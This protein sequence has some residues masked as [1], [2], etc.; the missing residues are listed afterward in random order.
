MQLA[1]NAHEVTESVLEKNATQ[2]NFAG[3]RLKSTLELDQG[4]ARLWRESLGIINRQKAIIHQWDQADPSRQK[5]VPLDIDADQL[6]ISFDEICG[7][8]TGIILAVRPGS[9]AV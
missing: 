8:G 9:K 2:T 4:A 5:S 3:F 1:V 6:K 7:G